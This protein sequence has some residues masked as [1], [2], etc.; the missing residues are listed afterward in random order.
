MR[1]FPGEFSPRYLRAAGRLVEVVVDP[2]YWLSSIRTVPKPETRAAP[3][4]DKQSAA[5]NLIN[6]RSGP[7]GVVDDRLE[8]LR[9]PH[10]INR[11]YRN[12]QDW[13]T[14][15]DLGLDIHFVKEK[16]II[17]PQARSADPV[18]GAM[19]L[20]PGGEPDSGFLL[21]QML[22]DLTEL[23]RKTKPCGAL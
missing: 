19:Q 11:I 16:V 15:E 3:C 22:V 5:P 8:S 7:W 2:G 13:A 18:T 21:Q 10:P 17:S 12:I 14:L 1:L 4:A 6:G 9:I 23:A 20:D